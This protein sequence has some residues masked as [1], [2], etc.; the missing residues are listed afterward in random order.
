[1]K[2]PRQNTNGL[3]QAPASARPIPLHKVQRP[4]L[5]DV[6]VRDI[7][8]MIV[9]GHVD[10][11]AK[12]NEP[13]ICEALG[14]SRTPVREALKLLAAEG[15]VELRRNRNPIVALV[16]A[17]ELAHLFEVESGIE[18]MAA[19]LSATR[20]LKADL[21]RLEKLQVRMERHRAKG[22]LDDYFEINQQ[23][24]RLVVVGARNPV[25]AETHGWLLGRLQRARYLALSA[26]GRWEQSVLEHRE[27]LE[28]LKHGDS[29]KAGRLFATH[30]ERTGAIVTAMAG[31]GTFGAGRA[32]SR[33]RVS[34]GNPETD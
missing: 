34:A 9:R 2:P 25:L 26:E 1:M 23:I 4:S 11:G 32:A 14:I 27:I 30:V 31:D 18:S 20:M 15:L 21:D 6:A 13:E 16:D 7:R 17:A 19:K 24:H 29:E 8:R 28:A 3:E 22:E 5:T 33:R 12:L 10:P